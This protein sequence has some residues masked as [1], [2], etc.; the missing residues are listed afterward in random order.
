MLQTI[1]KIAAKDDDDFK[2]E[3]PN[4]NQKY[5]QAK[6][7]ADEKIAKLLSDYGVDSVSYSVMLDGKIIMS[8]DSSA[9][10]ISKIEDLKD[11]LNGQ[12]NSYAQT[13]SGMVASILAVTLL[14]TG[15]I[16]SITIKS[17]IKNKRKEYGIY[18]AMGYTTKDLVKQ[19]SLSFWSTTGLRL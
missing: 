13:M 1:Y 14:I 2:N 8:G 9:Y 6:Q 18:K 10:K 4:E 11:Y 12:L 3:I 19:L 15:G 5:S 16:L 17:I 7:I